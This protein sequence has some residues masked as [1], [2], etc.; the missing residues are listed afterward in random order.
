MDGAVDPKPP[1]SDPPEPDV[2]VVERRPVRWAVPVL[3]FTLAVL[4]LVLLLMLRLPQDSLPGPTGS[5]GLEAVSILSGPARRLAAV[6]AAPFGCV[7]P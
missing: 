6:Q 5:P 2:V 3:L 7:R 4:L 1:A